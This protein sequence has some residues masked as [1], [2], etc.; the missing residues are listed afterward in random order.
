MPDMKTR[1]ARQARPATRRPKPRK[2]RILVADDQ[3]IDRCA[4]VSLLKSQRDFEIAGE[5][6]TGH[7]AASRCERLRPEVVLMSIRLPH[8]DG[9]SAIALIRKA[10]PS[11]HVVAIAERSAGN[12]LIL[13]PPRRSS[14]GLPMSRPDAAMCTDCLQL[15]VAG[16]ALG[17]LRRDAEPD[18]LFRAVRSVAQG[19]AWYEP[20]TASAI[21][22]RAMGAASNGA[23]ALSVRELDVAG[24]IADGRSNKE[25]GSALGISE[26]TVKKH[27]GH[28]LTK[29]GLQDRLQV[30]MYIVRN[31][32]L[33]DRKAQP[34]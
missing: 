31:P 24:L 23:K 13:N 2:I 6:A 27:V 16:G 21:L 7:D 29:L 30:G 1:A 10:S 8:L 34:S 18:E 15:A 5:C 26:P 17:A 25:I 11:T 19:N 3:T 28:L 14:T 33:L 22:K 9:V 4:L 12:C 32:L 20:N